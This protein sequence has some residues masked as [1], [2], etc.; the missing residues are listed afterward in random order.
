MTPAE[1]IEEGFRLLSEGANELPRT[2]KEHKAGPYLFPGQFSWRVT[3]LRKY[4][5][6]NRSKYG[7]R[8]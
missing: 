8:D 4:W 1:K 7:V 3:N 6:E 5:N 2:D